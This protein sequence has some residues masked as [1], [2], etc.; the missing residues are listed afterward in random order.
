MS[1]VPQLLLT[2]A[3]AASCLRVC[4][5]VLRRARQEGNLHFVLI[6]RSV[7]YT[8]EDLESFV[9]RQRKVSAPCPAPAPTATGARR[10]RGRGAVIVPFH[11]RKSGARGGD[12]L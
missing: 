6:G 5:R 12:S 7:R 1:Q 2:E 9:E 10:G 4:P 3:E 11:L 8:V